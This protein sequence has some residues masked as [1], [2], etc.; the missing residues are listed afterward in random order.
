MF[1]KTKTSLVAGVERLAFA[2]VAIA[3]ATVEF[4]LEPDSALA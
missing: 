3:P 4:W 2:A 1:L